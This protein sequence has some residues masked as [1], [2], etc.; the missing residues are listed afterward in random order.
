MT[1]PRKYSSEGIVLGKVNY[2]EADG[3]FVVF[4][5]DYGKVVL[6][7]KSVRK[8]KSRKRGSLEVFNRIKFSADKG[9]GVDFV[10]EAE[11]IEQFSSIRKSLRKLSLCYY[12]MEI[13]GK[14]TRE[15]EP[16]ES[17]Y[18]LI[19]RY[20]RRIAT[21][22]NLLEIKKEYLYDLSVI[23][24]FWPR[25]KKMSD[26]ENFIREVLERGIASERVGKQLFP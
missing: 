12:F 5:R 11:V 18:D 15:L 9:K 19:L 16:N 8:I 4:S 6:L 25:N 3:I 2:S 10:S 26:P 23:L 20:L 21:S 13:V 14:A 17:L 24:G 1:A 22:T 7:A